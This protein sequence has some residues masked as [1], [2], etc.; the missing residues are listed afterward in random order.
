MFPNKQNVPAVM[1]SV[2]GARQQLYYYYYDYI[3]ELMNTRSM[4]V[5]VLVCDGIYYGIMAIVRAYYLVSGSLVVV[6]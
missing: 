5:V 2:A 6:S 3:V 4:D 1:G